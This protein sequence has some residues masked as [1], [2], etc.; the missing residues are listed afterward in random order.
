MSSRILLVGGT[1]V[2]GSRVAALLRR[3]H[4]EFTLV[5]ASRSKEKGDALAAK[6]GSAEGAI[7]RTGDADPLATVDGPID[8]VLGLVHD[9]DDNLLRSAIRRGIPYSDI[10]RGNAALSRAFVTAAL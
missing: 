10:P 6:L 3:H 9:N 5:I 1:G 4:P 2:V 7:V 8:A